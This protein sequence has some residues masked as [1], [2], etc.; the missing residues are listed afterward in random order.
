MDASGRGN[1]E[2]HSHYNMAFK[3][4]D[5]WNLFNYGRSHYNMM[6]YCQWPIK[7]FAEISVR[8]AFASN[9]FVNSSR[10]SSRC[11]RTISLDDRDYLASPHVLLKTIFFGQHINSLIM[12]D[13]ISRIPYTLLGQRIIVTKNDRALLINERFCFSS[14]S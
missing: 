14:N 12:Y 7:S 2:G 13:L 9:F 5:Q 11:P 3:A 4:I 8:L 10:R 1:C 6:F